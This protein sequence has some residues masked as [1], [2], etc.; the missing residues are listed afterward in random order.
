MHTTPYL[1][2]TPIAISAANRPGLSN[3]NLLNK[4]GPNVYLTSDDDPSNPPSWLRGDRNRPAKAGSDEQNLGLSAAPGII[5]W[6]EKEHG[7]VDA[8]YFYFYSFN[9]GN[10]V[11][12]WRFGNHVG[13]WGESYSVDMGGWNADGG[14]EHTMVRFVNGEP[15]SMFFSEHSGGAA[16]E[17]SVVEK[18][19]K[20]VCPLSLSHT[21]LD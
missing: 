18:I 14:V 20:R 21:S 5:I 6:T 11:A 15:T 8:F 1:N 9:L 2:Y 16:Y 19:G 10:T 7:V 4:F 17:F 12:G 3:L 13:D